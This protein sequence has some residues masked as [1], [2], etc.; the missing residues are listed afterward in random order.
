MTV[1][2]DYKISNRTSLEFI[3]IK[4]DVKMSLVI[5]VRSSSTDA[6]FEK[7]NL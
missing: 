4:F 3:N 1:R 5:N 7:P 2:P 6:S